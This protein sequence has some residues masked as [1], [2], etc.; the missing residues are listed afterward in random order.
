MNRSKPKLTLK[1]K[2]ELLND[3]ENIKI[4]EILEA[5]KVKDKN[6]RNIYEIP[7]LSEFNHLQFDWLKHRHKES[8]DII[9][10]DLPTYY[11]ELN[12]LDVFNL[13][14][15][16]GIIQEV[17]IDNFVSRNLQF[18]PDKVFLLLDMVASASRNDNTNIVRKVYTP[19]SSVSVKETV[20]LIDTTIN[21]MRILMEQNKNDLEIVDI[22]G[23]TAYKVLKFTL[24]QTQSV[25]IK[26][27]ALLSSKDL[28][29]NISKINYQLQK[30]SYNNHKIEPVSQTYTTDTHLYEII[31]QDE[32]KMQNNFFFH[33][34]PFQNWYSIINNGLYVP[35]GK[36]IIHGNAY[37]SGIYLAHQATTSVGY[38]GGYTG[39]CIMGIAQVNNPEKYSKG[40]FLVVN[41][42]NDVML[43]Y[44]I[45]FN[46][47]K[48]NYAT[49]SQQATYLTTKLVDIQ[50]KTEVEADGKI[51][52][53]ICIK[54]I[55]KELK[56][57]FQ[58]DKI[59]NYPIK[60]ECKDDEINVW[61][62]TI[63]TAD[64]WGEMIW[65]IRFDNNYPVK[66]PFI[67]ILKPYFKYLSGHIT[68]GGAFCNPILTNQ[69]WRASIS[70]SN[71]I[72]LLLVNMEDGGAELDTNTNKTPYSL[73]AARKAY[74]RYKNAHGWD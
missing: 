29:D 58:I 69:K 33:G 41:D 67:R 72:E 48:T 12:D 35:Q 18:Y 55:N 19:T 31:Y 17:C 6:E 60:V 25:N 4:M 27:S 45:V 42:A 44:I 28:I 8:L 63:D 26:P 66:P 39:K 34:S 43:K 64:K 7:D 10:Q 40:N 23:F 68:I 70:I 73:D 20:G 50:R 22:I 30:T 13:L 5:G 36:Q 59:Y 65:E 21:K 38:L 14:E 15:K 54:R 1:K 24:Y 53:R 51:H 32:R 57:I 46:A 16:S 52:N 61:K 11:A 37:G 3:T 71:L 74:S 9:S 2:T 47:N 56:M 62:V 49:I